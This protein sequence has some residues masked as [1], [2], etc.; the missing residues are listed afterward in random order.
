[1]PQDQHRIHHGDKISQHLRVDLDVQWAYDRAE[2]PDAEPQQQ[3][4]QVFVR[5]QQHAAAFHD[6]AALKQARDRGR[7]SIEFAECDGGSGIQIDDRGL[8][9]IAVAIQGE[10]FPNGAIRDAGNMMAEYVRH[11]GLMPQSYGPRCLHSTGHLSCTIW[12]NLRR[13]LKR[14]TA[15]GTSANNFASSILVRRPPATTCS[16]ITNTSRT[17]SPVAL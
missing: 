1:M 3:F 16:P 5:Q 9:P 6:A 15:T 2:T 7:D 10:Q 17:E 4:F 13:F 11:D 14:P 8:G 12:S